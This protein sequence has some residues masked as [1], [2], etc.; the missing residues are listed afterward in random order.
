MKGDL[1]VSMEKMV[2]NLSKAKFDRTYLS[3]DGS[4]LVLRK[5]FATQ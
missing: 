3:K 4:K 2:K 5:S 1:Q